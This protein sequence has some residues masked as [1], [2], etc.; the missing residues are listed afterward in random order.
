MRASWAA[1]RRVVPWD[2]WAFASRSVMIG[3][4]NARARTVSTSTD[5][6][7]EVRIRVAVKSGFA[8]QK[9]IAAD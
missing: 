6:V 7:P 4:N 5:K 9:T 3:V 8:L 2:E 1:S